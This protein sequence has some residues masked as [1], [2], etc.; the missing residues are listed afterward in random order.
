[1]LSL[2]KEECKDLESIQSNTTPDPEHHMESDKTQEKITYNRAKRSALSQQ[3]ITMLQG[4]DKTVWQTNTKHKNK[5]D[6]QKKHRLG[7][8]SKA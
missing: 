4:T 1:M 6:L 2:N 3:V 5:T 7:M 8:V